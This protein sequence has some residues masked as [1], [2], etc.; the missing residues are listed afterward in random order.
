MLGAVF[1]AVISIIQLRG[2]GFR[3][4]NFGGL[5]PLLLTNKIL[6][7]WRHNTSFRESPGASRHGTGSNR[8]PPFGSASPS[9]PGQ[10]STAPSTPIKLR[11]SNR[12]P[13]HNPKPVNRE[14]GILPPDVELQP[15]PKDPQPWI[16]HRATKKRNVKVRAEKPHTYIGTGKDQVHLG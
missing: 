12:Y 2:E 4:L 3:M 6:K 16:T 5:A 1:E 15:E 7:V 10:P 9:T 13:Q 8:R 11:D 14:E